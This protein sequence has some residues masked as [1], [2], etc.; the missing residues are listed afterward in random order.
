[1]IFLHRLDGS[2][3]AVNTELIATVEATPDTMLTLTN[4][5]RI[6]VREGVR[7]VADAITEYRRSVHQL[8]GLQP[9]RTQG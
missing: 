3:V 5:L 6:L 2:E 9:V 4:G 1:M 7:E 8:P